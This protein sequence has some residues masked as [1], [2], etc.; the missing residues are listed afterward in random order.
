[1]KTYIINPDNFQPVT[2]EDWRKDENPTRAELLLIQR[3]DLPG[4]LMSKSYIMEDGKVKRFEFEEAQKACADFH[5][6]GADG[7]T[8]RAPTR[9]EH[10][11]MY[12]ARFLADLDEAIKLTGGNFATGVGAHWT[13]E[14]DTDPRCNEYYAWSAY[15][16]HGCFSYYYVCSSYLALPVVLYSANEVSPNA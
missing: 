5:P 12:D 16:H 6:Q 15:G 8:F 3:D 13:S 9:K 2:I 14:R 7:L 1:M 4:I 10:V 11:D